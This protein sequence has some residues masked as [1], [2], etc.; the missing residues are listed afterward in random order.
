MTG[1]RDNEKMVLR[2]D[3]AGPLYAQIRRAIAAPIISGTWRPGAAIP[4]ERDLCVRFSA[5]RMTVS[6]ALTLLAD[7][8]LIVRTRRKGSFVAP[9]VS[10]HASFE[11]VDV[12]DEVQSDGGHYGYELLKK[13]IANG[14]AV[15]LGDKALHL[16][17]RHSRDQ[18]PVLLEER[19]ID[20]AAAPEAGD[21]DF[22]IERPTPWLLHHVPWTRAE[23]QMS[24]INLV[25]PNAALLALEP[26]VACLVLERRTWRDQTPVT[27]VKNTYAGPSH[28]LIGRFEPAKGDSGRSK[29]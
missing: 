6:R 9:Q 15:N 14:S 22:S 26:G 25:T 21:Q 24:A 12:C 28:R 18:H 3:G 1:R 10:H 4:F 29:G 16:L 19:W 8:G 27:Y 11:I 13:E 7:E 20:L 23:H 2:L 17:C 5:S